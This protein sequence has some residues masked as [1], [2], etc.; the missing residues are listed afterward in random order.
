MDSDNVAAPTVEVRGLSRT[1]RS[2]R[3]AVV[4]VDNLSLEVRQ[5]EMLVLL[6]PSG[7][8]KTTLL[9][10]I[11]GLETPDSGEIA[12]NGRL[13]YSSS[14]RVL[15]PPERRGASMVFQSYALWPHMTVGDN[16]AYALRSQRVE[17]SEIAGRT[18]SA[19]DTVGCLPFKERF[20]HQ[21]SGGQ[22]QRVALARAIASHHGVILFDEPLSNVDAKVRERL[23]I[24]LL[25]LQRRIGFSA[26][27]VTHDQTE[28]MV[29]ASRNRRYGARSHHA[30]RHT[31][32]GL[33]TAADPLRG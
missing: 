29:I 16:V 32:G 26:V 19:L 8:G 1:F 10:S 23:R 13:V 31:T 27:Y 2:H 7:C 22:Q 12:V 11:A 17:K 28:A 14:K 4:A 6:G 18:A 20:P 24:E 30:A 3:A 5:G 33:R 21:L 25:E 15:V 9:R